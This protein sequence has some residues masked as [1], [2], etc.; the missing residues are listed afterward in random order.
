MRFIIDESS[1][2]QLDCSWLKKYSADLK[3]RMPISLEIEEEEYVQNLKLTLLNNRQAV[4]THIQIL[5][6]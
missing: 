6:I 1:D 4:F 3:K 5:M 2:S